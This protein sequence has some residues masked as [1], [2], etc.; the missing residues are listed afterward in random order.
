MLNARWNDNLDRDLFQLQAAGN[1]Y[2]LL[3]QLLR[4]GRSLG[5][6]VHYSEVQLH[7]DIFS[8]EHTFPSLLAGSFS[9]ESIPELQK[10]KTSKS[11]EWTL[12]KG[13]HQSFA[14]LSFRVPLSSFKEYAWWLFAWKWRPIWKVLPL[15]DLLGRRHKGKHGGTVR[16]EWFPEE[17][18]KNW[19][20]H[21]KGRK[22]PSKILPSCQFLM[23]KVCCAQVDLALA[24]GPSKKKAAIQIQ[25]LN[26]T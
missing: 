26:W 14:T 9:S 7:R 23:G 1:V 25:L 5:R 16:Q 11:W 3:V 24:W 4:E 6:K 19:W 13:H 12:N 15:Q 8:E 21:L 22:N 10:L 20:N 18:G 17:I 2:F